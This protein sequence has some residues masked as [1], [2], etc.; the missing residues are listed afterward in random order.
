MK[1]RLFLNGLMVAV[2]AGLLISCASSDSQR[3]LPRFREEANSDIVLRFNSWDTIHM[4][5]P[6]SRQDGFLPIFNREDLARD[7]A[8]RPVGRNLAVVVVGMNYAV[9]EESA[10]VR[11]WKIFFREQGF[12]RM[13]IL[14][15]MGGS[16]ING[17]PILYDSIIAAAHDTSVPLRTRVAKFPSASGA[18]AANSSGNSGR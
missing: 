3:T 16:E 6:D 17:L 11:D 14:R 5:K 13:V 9:D 4:T 12:R 2:L 18:D 7:L 15:A 1:T 8:K 10:L